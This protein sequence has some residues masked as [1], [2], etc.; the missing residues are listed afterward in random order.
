MN[1]IPRNFFLDD[2]FDD[3]LTSKPNHQFKCDIYEKDN[4]YHIEM[5]A[6]GFSKDNLMVEVDNGYVTIKLAKSESKEDKDKNYIRRERNV[7]E[8]QRS[9]YVGDVDSEQIKATF[10]DGTIDVVVPKPEL[11]ETKKVIAIE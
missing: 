2:V 1:L 11:V 7:T 10:K 6:P 4:E 9:F 8:Y 5:D 3:F